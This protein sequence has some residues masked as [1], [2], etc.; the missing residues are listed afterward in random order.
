MML[1]DMM[2]LSDECLFDGDESVAGCGIE[3][4]TVLGIDQRGGDVLECVDYADGDGFILNDVAAFDDADAGIGVGCQ[5]VSVG[6]R[7]D[8]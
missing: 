6:K 3:G 8:E 5:Q 7:S 4:L 1:V 2:Y